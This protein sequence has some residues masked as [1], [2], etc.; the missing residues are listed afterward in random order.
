MAK[1]NH[2]WS[3]GRQKQRAA[4]IYE[5]DLM[6]SIV[7]KVDALA[8]KVEGITVSQHPQGYQADFPANLMALDDTEQANYLGNPARPQNN[9]YSNTY[10]P[11]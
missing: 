2:Q 6:T 7:A 10:N 5:V 3:S 9:P 4:G 11:G 1:N 8:K